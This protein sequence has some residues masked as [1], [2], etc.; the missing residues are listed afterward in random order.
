[1]RRRRRQSQQNVRDYSSG[2]V[3]QRVAGKMYGRHKLL[4][5]CPLTPTEVYRHLWTQREREAIRSLKHIP[6]ILHWDDDMILSWDL[7]KFKVDPGFGY[8]VFPKSLVLKFPKPLPAPYTDQWRADRADLGVSRLPEAMQNVLVEWGQR[9]VRTD[10]EKDLVISKVQAV[11]S[12]CNTMGQIHR[13]WPNLCSFLPDRAQEILRN[14]KVRSKLPEAVLHYDDAT[15]PEQEH[16]LLDDDWKP[17]A[18]A[19]CAQSGDALRQPK[20]WTTAQRPGALGSRPLRRATD[21]RGRS[22]LRPRWGCRSARP[23]RAPR[24]TRAR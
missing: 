6:S 15:D 9:W 11:F 2:E 1:M 23:S 7:P 21:H 14:K 16:P 13:L 18:L 3:L 20:A 17:A 22:A 24:K 5:P 8:A 12:V 19:P 10:H 4:S